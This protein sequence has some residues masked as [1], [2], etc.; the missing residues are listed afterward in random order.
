MFFLI[1]NSLRP[2]ATAISGGLA[3]HHLVSL[4]CWVLIITG[5]GCSKDC[6]QW[7]EAAAVNEQKNANSEEAIELLQTA[8]R[9]DPESH[10]IKIRLANLLAENDQG[11]LGLTL[12][13]EV[14]EDDP[15]AKI[16]WRVRSQCLRCLGRFDEALA[17]SQRSYAHIIDK[18]CWELN[19]LAYDRGLA[20][21]ELDKA[22]RQINL[23]VRK[24]ERQQRWGLNL[25]NVPL[26]ISSIVSA[27]LISRHTD[28]GHLLALDL[29]NESIF[30]DQQLWLEMNSRLERLFAQHEREN[31]ESPVGETE[32]MRSNRQKTEEESASDSVQLVSG[33]LTVLLATRSLIFEDQGQSELADLD[34]L[35]LKRIGFDPQTIYRSLPND[36]ECFRAL[37]ACEHILDT[38]GFILTQMPWKPTWTIPTGEV[39]Q[40]GGKISFAPFTLYDR[41]SRDQDI[42]VVAAEIHLL[43]LD[44]DLVNRID[45]PIKGLKRGGN[46]VSRPSDIPGLKAMEKRMVAVLRNHRRQ[47]HLKANHLKA[48]EQDLLRIQ[49]LGFEAGPNLF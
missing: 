2:L 43:A 11:D 28:G 23:A 10:S 48:A 42:A 1:C 21:V 31:Q 19:A 25:R 38:R 12:C 4:C 49:E 30:S 47:A 17:D 33:N 6:A 32:E 40:L 27:G 39:S 16:A 5:I 45:F 35:W 9:V 8:L 7:K 13:D 26:E 22:L 36:A 44:S 46:L 3:M 18:D 24:Y 37:Q 34:R 20:G 29:L 41:A 14:L 15:S